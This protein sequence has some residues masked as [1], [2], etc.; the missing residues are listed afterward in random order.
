MKLKK[1]GGSNLEELV[2]KGNLENPEINAT[3]N[4]ILPLLV[5]DGVDAIALSCTHYPF[6]KEKIQEIVGRGVNVVDS[7]GAV[8]RRLKEVLTNNGALSDTKESEKY[9]TTG[10]I[11][12]FTRVG[13]ELVQKQ[14][15]NV[16][17]I[18]L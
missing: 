5:V 12:N 11:S 13:S 1:I 4:K 6:L 18:D 7:G 3:L 15:R 14:L 17:H 9:Y 16:E 8:A 2:E 10:D